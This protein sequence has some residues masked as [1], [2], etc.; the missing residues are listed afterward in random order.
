MLFRIRELALPFASSLELSPNAQPRSR[1]RVV[2]RSSP[3]SANETQPHTLDAF[4]K[5]TAPKSVSLSTLGVL[6][7]GD[8]KSAY[9]QEW[10]KKDAGVFV[11]A[12]SHFL[13]N[14]FA[15]ALNSP[16]EA[17]S[18]ILMKPWKPSNEKLEFIASQYA[19]L[20]LTNTILAFKGTLDWM[21]SDPLSACAPAA[22]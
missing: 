9:A 15:R 14:P 1:L 11:V 10:S 18:A 7:E 21:V 20:F 3:Q 17:P 12:S 16:P 5:W 22:K 2:L 6:V 13:T 4:Y 19:Q 8:L